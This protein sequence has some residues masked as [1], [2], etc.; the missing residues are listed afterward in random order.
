MTIIVKNTRDMF[1][2]ETNN[3]VVMLNKRQEKEIFNLLKT[4]D[5]L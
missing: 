5:S 2:K 3:T 1:E 4:R